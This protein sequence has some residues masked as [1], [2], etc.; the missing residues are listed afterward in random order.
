MMTH[1]IRFARTVISATIAFGCLLSGISWLGPL[2]LPLLLIPSWQKS[3]MMAHRLALVGI[4]G[5]LIAAVLAFVNACYLGTVFVRKP[6]PHWKLI[7]YASVWG[8]MIIFESA[9]WWFARSP[10]QVRPEGGD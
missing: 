6:E 5:C 3:R 9:S 1:N 8:M 7:L 10:S 4:I 2:A